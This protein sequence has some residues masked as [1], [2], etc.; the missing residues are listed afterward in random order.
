MRKWNLFEE[1]FD[2]A[3]WQN[4]FHNLIVF[5]LWP[6]LTQKEREIE[7]KKDYDGESQQKG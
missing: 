7:W 6:I 2:Q 1:T 3:V 4:C 5:W